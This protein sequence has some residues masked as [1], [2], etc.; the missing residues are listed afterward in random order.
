[1]H[2]STRK[3]HT[4]YGS[5]GLVRGL[6]LNSFFAP[7]SVNF[8]IEAVTGYSFNTDDLVIHRK[9]INRQELEG[10]LGDIQERRFSKKMLNGSSS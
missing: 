9:S 7:H 1:V 2:H 6:V 8:A 10:Y 3:L 4:D 5:G